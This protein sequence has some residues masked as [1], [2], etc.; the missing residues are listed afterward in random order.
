MSLLIMGLGERKRQL[1]V[2]QNDR[3]NCGPD[4]EF[5]Q[6]LSNCIDYLEEEIEQ[7]ESELTEEQGAQL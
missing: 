7:M 5:Y 6:H 4:P 1:A 3:E 2:L